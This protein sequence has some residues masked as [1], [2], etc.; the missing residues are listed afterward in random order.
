M[1]NIDARKAVAVAVEYLNEMRDL[2]DEKLKDIRLEELELSDEQGVWV[3]TLGYD[4][5]VQPSRLDRIL[6]PTPSTLLGETVHK[7]DY[8]TFQINSETGAVQSMKIRSV[9]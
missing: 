4:V 1:A 8:K 5:P 6:N 2:V 7:R 3:I 9:S